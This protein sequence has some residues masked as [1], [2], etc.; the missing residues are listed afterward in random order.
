[1]ISPLEKK[2]IIEIPVTLARWLAENLQCQYAM[3]QDNLGDGESTNEMCET[4]N[5]I[6]SSIVTALDEPGWE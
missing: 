4:L 1:M 6:Y 2:V 3:E 5:E